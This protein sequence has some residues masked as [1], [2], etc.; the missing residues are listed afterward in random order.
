MEEEI[1]KISHENYKDYT[2]LSAIAFSF[3]H[4]GAMGNGGEIIVITEEAKIY[5]MNF[6]YGNIQIEMCFEVCPPLKDCIFGIFDVE[7]TPNGWEGVN[8]G[9]GNYLVLSQPIYIQL[10]HEID[11]NPPHILYGKWKD[12]VLDVLKRDNN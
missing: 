7:R 10:K 5:S 1:K 2:N 11:N 12:L 8:L 4:A 9:Y 3:A 6:A